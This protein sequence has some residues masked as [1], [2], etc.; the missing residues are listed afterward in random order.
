MHLSATFSTFFFVVFSSFLGPVVQAAVPCSSHKECEAIFRPGS[1]C[2]PVTNTCTNP[3]HYGGCLANRYQKNIQN[4]SPSWHKIRVCGSSDPPQAQALGH[5]RASPL[6]YPEFRIASQNWESAIMVSWVFQ[7][8]LSEILD[9]PTS[10]EMGAPDLILDFY[11]ETSRFDWGSAYQW[12]A[13]AKAK[14]VGDCRTLQ[15]KQSHN[16]NDPSEDKNDSYEPCAHF[17]AEIWP[18]N[19]RVTIGNMVKE[20]AIL[21][22]TSLGAFGLNN[23]FIPFRTAREHPDLTSFFGLSLKYHPKNDLSDANNTI[24]VTHQRAKRRLLAETF[25]RPTTWYDYCTDVS[26]DGCAI[27]DAVATRPPQDDEHGRY[28]APGAYTGYFRATEQSNCDLYPDTCTGV[29]IDFP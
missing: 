13:L 28:F 17:M 19:H 20:G 9:V 6:N 16:N 10:I 3:L 8:I 7:I 25:L 12:N 2:S 15:Q 11:S 4:S 24:T 26:L 23:F 5:C 27:P 14:Q 22:P 29:F 18:S 1:Q 21:P